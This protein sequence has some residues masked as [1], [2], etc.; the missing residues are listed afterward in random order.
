MRFYSLFIFCLLCFVIAASNIEEDRE[1]LNSN[2]VH[3]PK[4]SNDPPTK[5][6][7][8]PKFKNVKKNDPMIRR[9]EAGV[10]TLNQAEERLSAFRR[11]MIKYAD[12]HDIELDYEDIMPH[13]CVDFDDSRQINV[14]GM[15]CPRCSYDVDCDNY[16]DLKRRVGRWARVREDYA[17]LW[18]HYEWKLIEARSTKAMTYYRRYLARLYE[19]Y[20]IYY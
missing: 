7:I 9:F 2:S 3:S 8:S 5:I 19:L 1:N 12:K 17:K 6:V 16:Y 20:N 18:A 11:W 13:I 10:E 14:T 4:K 15:E